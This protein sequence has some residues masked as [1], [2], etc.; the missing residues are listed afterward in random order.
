MARQGFVRVEV[1]VLK[2]DHVLPIRTL[3]IAAKSG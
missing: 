1:N 2:E 3:A